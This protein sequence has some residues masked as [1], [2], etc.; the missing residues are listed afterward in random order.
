MKDIRGSLA[1]L[2]EALKIGP[3]EGALST[4]RH[5]AG[6][7]FLSSGWPTVKDEAWRF[8]NL[9]KLAGLGLTPVAGIA[10]KAGL[11]FP[12]LPDGA[13]LVFINGVID[14]SLSTALPAGAELVALADNTGLAAYLDDDRLLD[15]GVAC[16]SL[17]VMAS[18]F[19][20][21]INAALDQPIH[22]VYR[23]HGDD[24]STHAV[25][26]VMLAAQASAT[27]LEHHA[28]TGDGLSAPI[29]AFAVGEGA[30]LSHARVQAESGTRH[31]LATTIMDFAQDA[32]YNGLSVQT[33]GAISRAENLIALTGE[34][35]DMTMTTLYLAKDN[36][37]MDVTAKVDHQMPNCTSRQIVRGVLD[38]AAKGIFQ[39]KVVVAQDAQKTDGNQMSRALLLSRKCEA[40]AKP[41]L[42]IYADDV[43]C[44]HG[45]TVGE[46]DDDHL[47]Y[48]TSRGI[49]ATEA[50]QMLI[51]AFLSDVLDGIDEG[52]KTHALPQISTWLRQ[53]KAEQKAARAE[54]G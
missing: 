42:E 1:M 36:Q 4:L 46:L 51:E 6:E 24:C 43:V 44:S 38:G 23:N 11:S 10:A 2:H 34:E 21:R 25:G 37:V 17:A 31:H 13:R 30:S 53:L 39:G 54:H 50:R 8:T 28:G 5:T 40:D 32:R 20:L 49:P 33:G 22:L 48:L 14:P 27:V 41:E 12:D 52:L 45:A 9:K 15:H 26:V 47:F 3:Q 29:L 16:L 18:G 19:G 35:V 7:R